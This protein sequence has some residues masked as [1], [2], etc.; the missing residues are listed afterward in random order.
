MN[1]ILLGVLTMYNKTLF[2]GTE[3]KRGSD[4][5]KEKK[6]YNSKGD[7]HWLGDGSYLYEEDFYAYKWIIDMYKRKYKN[8]PSKP[9]HLFERYHMLKVNVATS[10]KRIFDLDTARHKMYYD[11]VYEKCENMKKY[12]KRFS[13]VNMAEGVV[14]NIMFN[15][16]EYLK[17]YDVVIAT[18]KRRANKYS[19]KPM[20]LKYMPE[21]QICVKNIC[22]AR[23]IKFYKCL[24]KISE[25]QFCIDNLESVSKLDTDRCESKE[26]IY[27]K[28]NKP[29]IIN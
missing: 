5:L 22:K 6:M 23:P 4:M 8:Y 10:D 18:F 15:D 27:N 17:D 9:E 12:S 1:N 28:T 19:G 14:L 2:H 20:R 16:M 13:K 25:F 29:L 3:I 24:D 26:S 7:R 11:R 21:K